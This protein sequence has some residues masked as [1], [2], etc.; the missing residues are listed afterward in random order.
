MA[1]TLSV[2]ALLLG[3]GADRLR[4]RGVSLPTILAVAVGIALISQM[5]L[6]LRWP[7][8]T[9][10]PWLLIATT[11]AGTVLSFAILSEMFPSPPPVAPTA[12]STCCT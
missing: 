10:L 6:V 7:V 5:A 8:P 9:W 12:P 3:I 4:R 11:G 1:L 2:S